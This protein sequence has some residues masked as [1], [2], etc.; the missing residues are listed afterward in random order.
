[1]KSILDFYFLSVS[2]SI[3]VNNMIISPFF[4]AHSTIEDELPVNQQNLV[5]SR[6][7]FPFHNIRPFLPP[8]SE[9]QTTIVSQLSAFQQPSQL[10]FAYLLS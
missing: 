7:P 9:C 2:Y 4:L 1:M 10:R 3:E 5:I 6:W 8:F